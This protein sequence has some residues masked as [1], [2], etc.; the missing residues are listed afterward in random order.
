MSTTPRPPPGRPV[1][2]GR[3]PRP[4]RPRPPPGRALPAAHGIP[5]LGQ[6]DVVHFGVPGRHD[7]TEEPGT[8]GIHQI[9]D[10]DHHRPPAA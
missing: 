5:G 1:P 3:R 7:G 8:Q 2:A 6:G 9:G 10:R 4:G